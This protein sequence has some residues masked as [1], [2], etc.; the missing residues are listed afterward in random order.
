MSLFIGTLVIVGLSCLVMALGVLLGGKPLSGGC[1]KAP[2]TPQ[3]QACPRRKE[4]QAN[5]D[6]MGGEPEC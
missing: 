6:D 5:I 2:G 4:E 3:C 1:G